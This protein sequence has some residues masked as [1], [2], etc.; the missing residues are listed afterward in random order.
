MEDDTAIR[1]GSRGSTLALV[2]ANWVA[3]RLRE[4]GTP[5]EIVII[6]TAGDDRAPD[7]AWGEG[8]FVTAIEQALITGRVDVAVHSAKDVPTDED[9]RLAIA[10]WTTREDPRDALVC[11]VRGTSLAS[12]P[13]GARVGTDSPRRSAFLRARRPD[14][15]IHP[16]SGNIDTR[17]RKLDEGQSD[18]LVLAVAGLTRL[19]RADRIDEILPLEV[20]IPAPGQGTLALQ[21]RAEDDRAR[22]ALTPLDDPES[23]VAVQAERAF[24][25]AT[26]GGCRSPIGALGEIVGG[27]LT[28]HVA[29]ETRGGVVRITDSVPDERWA[30]LAQALAARVVRARALPRVLVTRPEESVSDLYEALDRAG[31]DVVHVPTIEIVPQASAELNTA[32]ASAAGDGA[33]IV[34]TSSDGVRAALGALDRTA[35]A[36]SSARW[37][38]VGR[39][40]AA[41]LA[42]RGVRAFVPSRALG[43]TLAAELPITAGDRVLIVRGDIA[44]TSVLDIL[45]ERGGNVVEQIAYRTIEGPGR[46]RARLAA[47]MS[48]PFDVLTFASGSSVRGLLAL[49]PSGSEAGLRATP[50]VCIGPSTAAVAREHDFASV[51]ESRD[52]GTDSFVDAVTQVI[53]RRDGADEPGQTLTP[54]AATPTA[55]GGSR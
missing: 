22:R 49:A 16:L 26:G 34:A 42:L 7:T 31:L 3:D 19:G 29:A 48:A 8:A 30:E 6:R 18:A 13:R 28:L 43:A 27:M 9:P 54:A 11:R 55:A 51:I 14:L 21:T 4:Q 24:L 5:T 52:P 1:I 53:R 50:A 38:V 46:S 40:S 45:R 23:R 25:A 10:A 33:W 44:D 15:E 36:P 47:A 2:Q 37:A 35:T 17:L 12:L 32:L 39:A 41:L 20:A